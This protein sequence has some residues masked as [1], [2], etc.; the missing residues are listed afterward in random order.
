M[1]GHW[2]MNQIRAA[3]K[4]DRGPVI[5]KLHRH[6]L[7]IDL[8]ISQC[9]KPSDS[10]NYINATQGKNIAFRGNLYGSQIKDK[11]RASS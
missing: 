2:S 10:K 9:L 4:G 11:R 3:A 5:D 8:N 6:L 7:P 1:L